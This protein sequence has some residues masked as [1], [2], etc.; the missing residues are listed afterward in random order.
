MFS[1]ISNI[2]EENFFPLHKCQAPRI[3]FLK[4]VSSGKFRLF[5]EEGE[6]AGLAGKRG[7]ESDKEELGFPSLVRRGKV[8]EELGVHPG[9][10][11]KADSLYRQVKK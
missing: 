6:E 5:W 4:L 2:E 8:R 9:H 3:R 1:S 10:K 7:G 11:E